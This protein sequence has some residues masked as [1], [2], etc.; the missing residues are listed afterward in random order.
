MR[1]IEAELDMVPFKTFKTQHGFDGPVQRFFTEKVYQFS[2]PYTP[3]L[4]GEFET[5]VTIGEDYILYNS[6]FSLYLWQGKK[7]VDPKYKVGAFYN[8]KYGF[9]SRPGVIKE[10]TDE[11]LNYTGTPMRGAFWTNR[12]W[13]DRDDEIIEMTQKFS[14]TY[15]GKHD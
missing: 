1:E 8:E 11:P 5:N 2:S 3:K 10:Q 12:M 4:T 14:D 13:A 6:P 9:W 15:G 7:M